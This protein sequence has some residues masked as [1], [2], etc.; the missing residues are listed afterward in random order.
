[1]SDPS[2]SLSGQQISF[3]LAK[4][5]VQVLSPESETKATYKHEG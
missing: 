2:G 4:N 5:R 1:M 3:D